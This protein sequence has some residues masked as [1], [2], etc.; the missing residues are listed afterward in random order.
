MSGHSATAGEIP[1][2]KLNLSNLAV[3]SSA[4]IIYLMSFYWVGITTIFAMQI[5]SMKLPQLLICLITGTGIFGCNNTTPNEIPSEQ[6]ILQDTVAYEAQPAFQSI[7]D[8]VGVVGS[9]LLFDP[10]QATYYSNDFEWAELGRLPASTFKIPNSLIALETRVA[11]TTTVF[12][13]DGTKKQLAAWEQDLRLRDAFHVSCVPCYQRIARTVGVNRMDSMLQRL[14]YGNMVVDSNSIDVFWLSGESKINSFEQID[15][16]RRLYEESLP[17]SPSNR[18]II[19]ELIV[20]DSNEEYTLSGKTGWAIRDGHNN[21]WFVGYVENAGQ[22]YYFATNI[23]PKQSFNMDL[24]PVIRT[25]ITMA[26]LR[27]MEFIK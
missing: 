6:S 7:L 22:V 20:I 3:V 14:E 26:A 23:D 19:K 4:T 16:L 25:Q 8:S 12:E 27:E 10:K 5:P 21:G 11:D 18:K 17:V 1:D 13:W 9:I 15:F 2:W 24:F